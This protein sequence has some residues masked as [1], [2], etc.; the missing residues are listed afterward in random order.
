MTRDR[1]STI[2]LS[3]PHG[4]GHPRNSEGSFV[5]LA[6]GRITFACARYDGPRT[7]SGGSGQ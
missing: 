2:V 5:V 3:L 4:R 6:D 7:L 1:G